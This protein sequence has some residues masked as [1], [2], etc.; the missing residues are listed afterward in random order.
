MSNFYPK[1]FYIILILVLYGMELPHLYTNMLCDLTSANT[2][3]RI[4]E[5]FSMLNF[6]A[7]PHCI[8]VTK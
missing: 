3:M 6:A 1:T 4:L 5:V 2:S 7:K 8:L